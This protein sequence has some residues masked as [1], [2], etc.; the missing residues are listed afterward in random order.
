MKKLFAVLLVLSLFLVVGGRPSF[1][2]T[3][4]E[5]VELSQ[6]PIP[7]NSSYSEGITFIGL[8]TGSK[9]EN[10]TQLVGKFLTGAGHVGLGFACPQCTQNRDD[11]TRSTEISEGM[12]IGLVGMVDNQVTAMFNS[13]PNIDVVA[14]LADEWIPGHKEQQSVY[15]SGY[16]DLLESGI[17]V[18]WSFSRNL[19]Y[20]GFVVV[21]IVVGFMIM[22]R[23]KVGGQTL[24]TVGNSIPKVVVGLVL[25]TFS[26]AIAGLIL[27][28]AGVLMAVFANLLETDIEVY[29]IWELLK[30]TLGLG[31]TTV[32]GGLGIASIVM[33]LVVSLGPVGLIALLIAAVIIGIILFGAIK[34]W[35][36]LLKS[37][38]ALLVN[39]V[40]SPIVIMAGSIPG[41]STAIS[42]LFKS[43]L[44]NALV[45]PVAFAIV[46]GVY[47]ITDRQGIILSFP[48]SLLLRE[49]STTI[50][51]IGPLV[52]GLAKIIAI[53]V[54][55]QT[56]QFM[57]A[58]I[59]AT[60]SKA[61]A[62][63]A[64][65]VKEGFSKVP[66]IGGAFK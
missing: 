51:Q 49:S 13:Q 33:L 26:F 59:P 17:H 11:I 38:L 39:V 45:F 5:I 65:A 37:Y 22:F 58:I 8:L 50:N 52:T 62:D 1:A 18:L 23:N 55:A 10:I 41:N 47:F 35:L 57:K 31:E 9:G 12:K 24:V 14:H 4:E 29:N 46:N 21:M 28:F 30:G 43:I 32:F 27:D 7:D 56:P 3:P 64:A 40:V 44:R 66:L 34:L 20:L 2:E 60:A 6:T 15:A 25:V 48:P 36:A 61:G 19:A 42:N 54:A 63:A 16:Q 53:Y